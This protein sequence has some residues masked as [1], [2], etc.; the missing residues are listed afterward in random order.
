MNRQRAR[1][2]LS[3]L[4]SIGKKDNKGSGDSEGIN[5]SAMPGMTMPAQRMPS[6]AIPGVQRD[7]KSKGAM[8]GMQMGPMQDGSPPPDTRDP[9]AYAGGTKK[10]ALIG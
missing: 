1:Q 2:P 4:W 6:G 9:N 5:H 10:H 3:G 7:T 8:Q